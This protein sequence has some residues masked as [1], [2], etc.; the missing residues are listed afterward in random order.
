M[1][2]LVSRV[3]FLPVN[4]PCSVG[5][6]RLVNVA[7]GFL[8]TWLVFLLEEKLDPRS[9]MSTSWWQRALNAVAVG[10]FPLLFFFQ[11]M[12]YTDPGSTFFVLL[13]YYFLTH[14]AYLSSSLV[15]LFFQKKKYRKKN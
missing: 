4:D 3:S 7:F 9:A 6:L 15:C 14:R 5:F 12:Y 11:L 8:T 1:S 2:T 13:A 10:L